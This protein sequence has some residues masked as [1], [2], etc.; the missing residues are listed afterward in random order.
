MQRYR[1]INRSRLIIQ[2]FERIN[3][4]LYYYCRR[5]IIIIMTKVSARFTINSVGALIILC[6]VIMRT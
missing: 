4:E 1:L 5:V 6:S 2:L 3:N